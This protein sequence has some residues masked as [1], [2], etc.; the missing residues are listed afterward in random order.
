[1]C[2]VKVSDDALSHHYSHFISSRLKDRVMWHLSGHGKSQVEIGKIFKVNKSTVSR[3]FLEL[4]KPRR[5]V[6]DQDWFARQLENLL[7][8]ENLTDMDSQAMNGNIVANPA[9]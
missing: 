2:S 5:M 8:G 1:M 7:I 9:T 6:L 3:R 4:P